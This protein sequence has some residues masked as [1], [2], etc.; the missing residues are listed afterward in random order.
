MDVFERFESEVRSYIRGF[1]DVFTAA[2]GARITGRSGREY[3]DFFAGA[4]ALNYGHNDDA[5]KRRLVDYLAGDGI[6]HSLDMATAAKE[7]FLTAFHDTILAPRRMSHRMLFPAPSGA[8]AV[9]VALKLARKATGR[10]RIV[11]FENSFHG[12]TLG[13]MAVSG[14]SARQSTIMPAVGGTTFIPFDGAQGPGVDTLDGLELLLSDA[15][16]E[17]DQPAACIVETIQAEGGINVASMEWLRRLQGICRAAG[18]LLI[19]DDIQVGC[20]R[21]GPFFSFEAAGL[22]PDIVCLS[23]SLS[24]LGLPMAM[25]LVKPACDS[26][27]PGEHSGT[28]R[29]FN[30][31]FVT[32]TEALR[33][34]RDDALEH[35]VARKAGIVHARLDGIALR[36]QEVAR[37]PVRG[38]GLIQGL[39][40]ASHA[41]ARRIA[42]EAFARGLVLES[43]GPQHEVLKVLCPLT[44]ADDD[45]AQGLDILDAAVAAVAAA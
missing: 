22:D 43:C 21:T 27:A 1:P 17:A 19:V 38:R 15:R 4:G 24:G 8:N 45:L 5:M 40:T 18:M 13:A 33:F 25:V 3:I 26:L 36:Y 37:P 23:K 16:G 9:E 31:A 2:R 6:L 12:M 44:I 20:G 11:S 41:V 10:Q 42:G 29:G 32:A 39:P 34:W 30:P 28:F 35:E 7:T 14:G